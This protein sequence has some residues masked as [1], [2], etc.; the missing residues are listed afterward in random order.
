MHIYKFL[1]IRGGVKGNALIKCSL[2]QLNISIGIT[3]KI[4]NLSFN[5]CIAPELCA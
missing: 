1:P 5:N 2:K 3:A 4:K